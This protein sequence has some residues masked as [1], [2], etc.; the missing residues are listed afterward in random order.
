MN[1]KDLQK[2]VFDCYASVLK[3]IGFSTENIS[4]STLWCLDDNDM[5]YF[6]DLM[7][8]KIPE[9]FSF[10]K[11]GRFENLQDVCF[12]IESYFPVEEDKIIYPIVKSHNHSKAGF[13]F[14]RQKN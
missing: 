5:T 10:L 2:T 7:E 14:E 11:E 4:L 8:E 6:V 9:D 12:E 3:G 1:R 13:G